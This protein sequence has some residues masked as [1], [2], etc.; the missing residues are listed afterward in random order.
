[1]KKMIVLTFLIL[2]VSAYPSK[3]QET[4]VLTLDR[5]INIALSKSYTVKSYQEKKLA[6]Q[7]SFRYWEAMFKPRMDFSLYAPSWTE[8]VSPIQRVDGLPVYNSIGSMQ[9][10]GNLKF[11]Y[12]LPTGGNLALNSMLYRDNLKTVLALQDYETLRIRKA[13][14]SFSLSFEQPILTGNQLKE[15]LEEARLQ[16]EKMSNEF[17]R[18]RLD[19][20]YQ[21]TESFYAVYRTTR[22]VE[23]AGEKLKNSEEAY[24][25]A[26]LKGEAGRIPE[27]DML[28]AEVAAAQNRAALSESDGKL[29]RAKDVLKQLIGLELYDLIQIETDLRYDTFKID[30]DGAIGKALRYRL[31]VYENEL[32]VKLQEIGLDRAERIR[33]L[34]G[35]ISAYYDVT[36]VSTIEHGST[37]ELFRSSFNNFVDRPPNRGV[38]LTFS[39]PI[40]D[41]GRGRERVQREMASLREAQLS[42]DDIQ[43]TIIREVRDIVRSVEETM[44]RL[45]IHEKN[46]QLAQ[47]SYEISRMRFE[48]GNITSQ[49]LGTEQ[50]RLAATQLDYLNAYITYQL[51]IADL[52]RKTLWDFKNNSS[53]LVEEAYFQTKE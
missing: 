17:S 36:G 25:I 15:S 47:K 35:K 39:Y 51:A 6:M 12:T 53:Y 13:Q 37:A 34:S 31:E 2:Q 41:W 30:Q 40:F 27:G 7:H 3:A 29:E 52:K 42:L 11:T 48:N 45:I 28:I 26:K 38:T 43:T 50:E 5:A 9:Y 32:D 20:I 23:I 49:E 16:Y 19:I 33:E 46:Q 24:R 4:L 22:E 10:S 8:N 14:S 44:N 18:R 1:M 21:V